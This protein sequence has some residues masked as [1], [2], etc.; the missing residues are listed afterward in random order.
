MSVCG[1]STSPPAM[2]HPGIHTHT[3]IPRFDLA[4]HTH[5]FRDLTHDTPTRTPPP[6]FL[7]SPV[8]KDSKE[9]KTKSLTPN[10]GPP[11]GSQG[12]V[13]TPRVICPPDQRTFN[14]DGT[15]VSEVGLKPWVEG[16]KEEG[17]DGE[18]VGRKRLVFLSFSFSFFFFFFF[19]SFSSS[20]CFFLG[21][22]VSMSR[23]KV[24]L[25]IAWTVL[26]FY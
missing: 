4:R 17:K 8:A 6:A 20:S 11:R 14:S 16:G 19:S 24:F 1:M 26:L 15:R 22:C 10:P 12:S 21:M 18:G 2:F 23:R 5:T 13:F 25:A 3:H 9:K 7:T